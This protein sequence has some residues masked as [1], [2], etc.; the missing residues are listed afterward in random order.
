M[1]TKSDPAARSIATNLAL[2]YAG[3]VTYLSLSPFQ[4]WQWPDSAFDYLWAG[5][6]AYWTDF[7][8][9]INVLAYVPLGFLFNI[10]LSQQL[11]RGGALLLTVAICA[12]LSLVL[13]TLQG[14]LPFFR[15]ASNV[16]LG[17]NILG[18]LLGAAL[19]S[20]LAQYTTLEAN[21]VAFRHWLF[22]PGAAVDRGAV[23][24]LLW[25]LAQ[26]N[27]SI[28]FLGAGLINT[29]SVPL[30]TQA[31]FVPWPQISSVALNF[32]GIGLL[33]SV[34]IKGQVKGLLAALL[35]ISIAFLLKSL[36]AVVMLK[37]EA[38]FD[39]LETGTT[40]G[41][42]SGILL[43]LLSARLS[44]GWRTLLAAAFVVAG[45]LLAKLFGHYS[46]VG[47]VLGIFSWRYGQLLNYT[48][49]TYYLNELWPLIALVFLV[50]YYRSAQSQR[51]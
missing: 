15:Y 28:P 33:L 50:L 30:E 11:R 2:V 32:C 25:L 18:A 13:E 16:D 27:P 19:A 14:F 17:C 46:G 29:D 12:L 41:M 3:L 45:A 40:I 21:F 24:L 22:Q 36:A 51:V 10:A 35:L 37:P 20:W 23:I 47:D 34:L 4:D 5:W 26:T 39:W 49:L 31:A 6:P 48:G 8:L 38:A 7:D 42:A 1:S 9:F 44:F 43:L